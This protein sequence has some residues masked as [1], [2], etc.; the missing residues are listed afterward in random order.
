[1][2]G[3]R[4]V[5]GQ[6]LCSPAVAKRPP[7]GRNVGVD[8]GAHERVHEVQGL[9]CPQQL[10]PGQRVKRIR[11]G[12]LIDPGH[13]S[14]MTQGR[15]VPEHRHG[16]SQIGSV[17]RRQAPEAN[18]HRAGHGRRRDPDQLLGADLRIDQV[19]AQFAQQFVEIEGVARGDLPAGLTEAG[20]ASAKPSAW[21]I[22]VTDGTARSLR[23]CTL[24][25]GPLTI[26]CRRSPS[27]ALSGGRVAMTRP[28][29][30]STRR[31]CR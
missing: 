27:A 3:G 20:P 19:R 16:A 25:P 17:R 8:G 5:G 28:T 31:R 13:R 1:M 26:L 9:T 14:G 7:G 30:W 11:G 18:K 22:S 2:L 6:Q 15:A 29:G 12:L 4:V 10:G 23:V 21:T 24:V